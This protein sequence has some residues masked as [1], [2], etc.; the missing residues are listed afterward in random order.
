MVEENIADEF[1]THSVEFALAI[2]KQCRHGV[3]PSQIASHL[4]RAHSVQRK[5]AA[6]IA[7]EVSSWAGLIRYSSEIEVPNQVIE[8]MHQLPIYTDGLMCQ[9]DPDYCRQIFRSERVMKNHWREV[10]NW[11]PGKRGGRPSQVETKKIRARMSKSYQEVYCQRLL[12]QG[13]G[14][15]YFQVYQDS[16]SGAEHRAR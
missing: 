13:Q 6:L 1:F 9:I 2:C 5:Q 3:L 11:S 14:S 7:E 4:Q 10:H 15:Q 16:N 12:V 8:P